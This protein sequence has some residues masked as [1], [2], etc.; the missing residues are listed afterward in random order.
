MLSRLWFP[1][2]PVLKT[3][4]FC[5]LIDQFVF[6]TWLK[7]INLLRPTVEELLRQRETVETAIEPRQCR[8]S[9]EKIVQEQTVRAVQCTARPHNFT[10]CHLANL[11]VCICLRRFERHSSQRQ[12]LRW[13][14]NWKCASDVALDGHI[15][16]TVKQ[17]PSKPSNHREGHF[18]DRL[19]GISLLLQLSDIG[20]D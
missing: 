20:G 8:R 14:E 13:P 9:V 12:K 10:W 19:L 1:L 18:C 16:W 15:Q 7:V 4:H 3:S 11:R 17:K 5:K 2:I 6:V